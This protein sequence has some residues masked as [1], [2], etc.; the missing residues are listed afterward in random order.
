M[1][2]PFAILLFPLSGF[3]A[4][5]T[6]YGLFKFQQKPAYVLLW[7]PITLWSLL[8]STA[9][10]STL[11]FLSEVSRQGDAGAGFAG[12]GAM[13]VLGR[14]AFFVL[15]LALCFIARPRRQNFQS[16]Y[17]VISILLSAALFSAIAWLTR[18]H[19]P[20]I[21]LDSNSRSVSNIN[22][23]FDSGED[24][25]GFRTRGFVK[26]DSEGKA[27]VHGYSQRLTISIASPDYYVPSGERNILVNLPSE[28]PIVFHLR[29][30][31]VGV[32]LITSQYGVKSY[33]GVLAP[34]DGTPVWVDILQR[35]SG[36][37]AG[38]LSISK[39]TP[40][41]EKWKEATEWYFRME[42]S[43][44][45]FVEYKDEFP[46][47]APA[48]GYQSVVEFSFRKDE[49]NWTINLNKDYY[50]Q[51]GNPPRYGRLHLETLIE[52]Q[53]ARLTYAINPDGSQYLEPK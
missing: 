43:D 9:F 11:G 44:G 36:G 45:G 50:I 7:L 2:A 4:A 31:G 41:Y 25:P 6:A 29:K 42:I 23:C 28:K 38:Q 40:P 14:T 27:V 16:G 19:L 20:V 48:S 22:V 1:L 13:F 5:L 24:I 17:A 12:L 51:F 52:M 35:K 47:E 18:N 10:I 8:G 15:A 30:K 46:F 32:D 34:T 33:F 39:T 37:Q 26:T 3:L 53:G 21:V 49:T